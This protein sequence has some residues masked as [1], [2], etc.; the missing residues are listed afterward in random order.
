M[1]KICFKCKVKKQLSEFYI[2]RQMLDGHLNKCKECTKKDVKENEK[3]YDFSEKGVIRVL[4]KTQVRNSKVRKMELPNYSK[5]ELRQWLYKNKFKEIYEEWV[6]SGYIKNK[7][8]SCDRIDDFKSY[9]L[10]NIILTTWEKNFNHA[11]NDT[12]NGIG[13][14]GR[15]C[16]KVL[17]L[18]KNMNI[19]AEYVSYTSARRI[20]NFCMERLIKT[21]RIDKNGYYWKYK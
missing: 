6:S 16:K 12:K 11:M 8:P 14:C 10:D 19:V 20:N 13:K 21:G 9:T 5:E 4:Y 3:N 1:S 7:K 2:H 17:Q 18:D 15:K